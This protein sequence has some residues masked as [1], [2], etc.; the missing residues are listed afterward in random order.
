[1]PYNVPTTLP[2]VGRELLNVPMG[3]MIRQMALAIADSQVAL[4][5][6][7]MDVADFMSRA[8]VEF[9]VERDNDGKPI[10][11]TS[12]GAAPGAYKKKKYSMLELG[13]SPTFY[14]FVDTII[15]VR[16]AIKVT[17]DIED[18]ANYKTRSATYG[19][20][21]GTGVTVQT[22][23]VDGTYTSKFGY[24]VEGSSLLRTK[25]V[26]IPPPA[27]LEQRIREEMEAEAKVSSAADKDD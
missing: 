20:K 2:N 15:E 3:D 7:S 4:D 24:S 27:I 18:K 16:I 17:L 21:K 10:A 1:M 22:S 5:R 8:R 12:D 26:P 9:G 14:Q 19:F 6:A 11:D 25:L 13:F 23:Q